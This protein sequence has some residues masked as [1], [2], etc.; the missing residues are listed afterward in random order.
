MF[1]GCTLALQASAVTVTG[2]C[3]KNAGFICELEKLPLC[4]CTTA[5][6]CGGCDPLT[7]A[8]CKCT[9]KPTPKPTPRPP[10]PLP[11]PPTPVPTASRCSAWVTLADTVCN[12]SDITYVR[13]STTAKC[14]A[15]CAKTALCTAFSLNT[16]NLDTCYLK[17]DCKGNAARSG[18]V[19]GVISCGRVLTA[20]GLAAA[21]WQTTG[22][23]VKN[24]ILSWDACAGLRDVHQVVSASVIDAL[25]TGPDFTC[26]MLAKK[27]L[28]S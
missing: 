17:T 25:T 24:H 26:S 18:H 6:T 23:K 27:C 9:P 3:C 8:N 11:T 10:T 15:L 21:Y 20:N 2:C 14:E 7:Q 28:F 12:G 4:K 16:V 1:A 22:S 5:Q 13:K 19:S